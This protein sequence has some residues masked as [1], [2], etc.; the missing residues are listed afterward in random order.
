MRR[1]GLVD[2]SSRMADSGLRIPTQGNHS[3]LGKIDS[4]IQF[5]RVRRSLNIR[6]TE[7]PQ[8][9]L[10]V[11]GNPPP[12]PGA[13]SGG[14]TFFSRAKTTA[15]GYPSSNTHSASHECSR[16]ITPGSILK[17][18]CDQLQHRTWT[19][20]TRHVACNGERK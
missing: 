4:Y 10:P 6:F 20:G 3:F 9:K 11:S 12:W 14:N 8:P 18:L 1:S 17:T 5:C 2:L 19:Q 13:L 15:A 7:E 16:P